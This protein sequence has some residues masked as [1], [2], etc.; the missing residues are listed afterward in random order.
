MQKRM[1]LIMN[2]MAGQKRAARYLADILRIFGEA[3]Y[4]CTVHMTRA[5]G[6][7][8]A[9]AC[10]RAAD[11]SLIVCIGGDGTLNEVLSGLVESGADT[12][13]GYIPAG[14]T[15]DFASSLGL[16]R[17]MLQAARDIVGGTACPLDIGRFNGRIFSY[18]ASCGAF[19]KTSYSTPQANKN[20][21]GH[22]AYIL[23]GIKDV[24]NL[25]QI[26]LRVQPDNVP[27]VEGEFILA[28]VSNATSIGGVLTLDKQRVS[29]HDGKLELL[30][31]R[32]PKN[33]WE[34]SRIVAS[35]Q[36]QKYDDPLVTFVSAERFHLTMGAETPWT[37]DGEFGGAYTEA[38]VE[39][40]PSAVRWML[41]KPHVTEA[42]SS[43]PA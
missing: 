33:L 7:G 5:R 41:G 13:I 9:V 25:K 24:G 12:P 35:L 22:L 40:C 4:E 27:P 11:F 10:A 18:V 14:S 17:N 37:L 34:L 38:D 16:S 29:M 1:L 19:A 39:V 42:L 20:A 31:L 26:H 21:L 8:R 32:Y 3:E 36:N 30:L 43:D 15:N 23:E 28:A 2:P 6:D